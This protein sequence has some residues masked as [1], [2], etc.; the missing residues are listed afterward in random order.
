MPPT[1]TELAGELH[2]GRVETL[3]ILDANPA[4]DAPG[5]LDIAQ[6][7]KARRLQRASRPARRRDGGALRVGICRCRIRSRAGP[8]CAP[9][10]APR[11]SFSR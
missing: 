2:D 4:Y 9:S 10:T 8:I 11:A 3:L 6:G 1:L 5:G 7:L